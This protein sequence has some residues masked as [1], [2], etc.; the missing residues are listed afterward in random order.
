MNENIKNRGGDNMKCSKCGNAD[1]REIGSPVKTHLQEMTTAK[2]IIYQCYGCGSVWDTAS[3]V[4]EPSTAEMLLDGA[5]KTGYI[6]AIRLV[7]NRKWSVTIG[8]YQGLSEKL[9]EA[10]SIAYKE[11]IRNEAIQ[12]AYKWAEEARDE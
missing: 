11:A 5:E 3:I 1:I 7:K 8:G 4:P 9:S 6:Q 2:E 10:V 12:Q